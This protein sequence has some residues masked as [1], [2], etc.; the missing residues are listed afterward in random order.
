MLLN[1]RQIKP[2]SNPM[3]SQDVSLPSPIAYH[4]CHIDTCYVADGYHEFP[5]ALSSQ[6][7]CQEKGE[8]LTAAMSMKP[9]MHALNHPVHQVVTV[10]Y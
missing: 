8:W 10:I 9:S 4:H 1:D 2:G 6:D 3:V 5:I 7:I